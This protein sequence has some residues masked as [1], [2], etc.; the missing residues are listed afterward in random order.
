[1][2]N[3]DSIV[4]SDDIGYSG[5][6]LAGTVR[7]IQAVYANNNLKPPKIIINTGYMSLAAYQNIVSAFTETGNNNYQIVPVISASDNHRRI[8]TVNDILKKKYP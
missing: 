1:M 4:I 2:A 6:Q 5:S 8:S 3:I 7:D